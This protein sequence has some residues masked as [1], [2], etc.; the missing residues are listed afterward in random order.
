[1]TKKTQRDDY[2]FKVYLG[3]TKDFDKKVFLSG[4]SW[5]CGWYWGGGNISSKDFSAH[6]KD[7]FLDTVDVRGH[8]LGN[9]VSPWDNN[10]SADSVIIRNGAS[11]WEDINVFLNDAQFENEW[12]YIKD[13]YRQFYAYRNAAEV[14]SRGGGVTEVPDFLKNP[15]L[16]EKINDSIE[17][18][19]I[20]EIIKTLKVK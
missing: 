17:N 18:V 2:R 6:F 4:F 12:W 16:G 9:F 14:Y 15:K 10:S 19:L 8:A 7:C 11:V 1:M 20:P 5:E 13:L 3:R